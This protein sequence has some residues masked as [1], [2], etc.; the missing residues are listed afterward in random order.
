MSNKP[1]SSEI[2]S[3]VFHSAP[4]GEVHDDIIYCG[5]DPQDIVTIIVNGYSFNAFVNLGH[6]LRQARHFWRENFGDQ[7]LHLWADQI[8]I[9]Q[10]S[11]SERSHQV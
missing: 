1:K 8:C 7:E 5:G 11:L 3:M 2:F 9:N 10:S 4:N 6:A